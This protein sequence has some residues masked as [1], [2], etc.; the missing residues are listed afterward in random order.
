MGGMDVDSF[1]S[2]LIEAPWIFLIVYGFI[3]AQWGV[4]L[5]AIAQRRPARLFRVAIWVFFVLGTVVTVLI[6]SVEPEAKKAVASSLIIW[7]IIMGN[8][9]AHAMINWLFGRGDDRI[10]KLIQSLR[11]RV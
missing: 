7:T 4:K 5:W 8:L 1:R 11:T 3:L 10:Q 9:T 6:L 2:I